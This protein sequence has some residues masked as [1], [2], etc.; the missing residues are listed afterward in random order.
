MWPNIHHFM[1]NG[2]FLPAALCSISH[3]R[4]YALNRICPRP[5]L[6]LSAVKSRFVYLLGGPG[7]I[8]IVAPMLHHLGSLIPIFAE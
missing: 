2:N 1:P 3:N 5:A 6:A 4:V 8:E 7:L